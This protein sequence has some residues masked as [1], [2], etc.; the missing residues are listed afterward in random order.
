MAVASE[1]YEEPSGEEASCKS[2]WQIAILQS[3]LHCLSV[4]ECVSTMLMFAYI[5]Q[6]GIRNMMLDSVLFTQICL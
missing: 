2:L 5:Y 1:V 3:V 4:L 6:V